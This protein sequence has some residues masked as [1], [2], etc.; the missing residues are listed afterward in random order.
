MNRP[1]WD[2]AK[3]ESILKEKYSQAGEEMPKV[4]LLGVRGYFEN[5]MGVKGQNDRGIYD[6]ALFIYA[7][8]FLKSFNFNTDPS[9]TGF[10][11]H[12][13]KGFAVLQPGIWMYKIGIHGLSKPS[14]KQYRAF[15][16]AGK[17]TIKRDGHDDADSGEFYGFFGVNIHRGGIN[18]TSSEGCQTVVTEQWAEFFTTAEALL[19]QHNQNIIDYVLIEQQG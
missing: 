4:V 9:R 11:E 13:G 6:D 15:V 17:V 19:N 1:Q 12:A 14:Y 10:N 16:Q 18:G 7:P 8:N 5:T 3:V 2:R